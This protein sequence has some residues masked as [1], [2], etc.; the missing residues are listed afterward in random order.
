[1]AEP[2]TAAKYDRM[3]AFIY[4]TIEK[5]NCKCHIF[6]NIYTF[7]NPVACMTRC[8]HVLQYSQCL[9]GLGEIWEF[10]SSLYDNTIGK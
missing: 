5:P 10:N 3:V 4:N 2:G 8:T 9:V 7:P 1:L 6:F